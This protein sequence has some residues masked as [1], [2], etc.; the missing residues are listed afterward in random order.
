MIWLTIAGALLFVAIAAVLIIN[1]TAS[2]PS[3]AV[4]DYLGALSDGDY[5]KAAQLANPA[6]EYPQRAAL[7][8]AVATSADNRIQNVR[9]GEQQQAIGNELASKGIT[10]G[11]TYF[12]VSYSIDGQAKTDYIGVKYQGKKWLFIDSWVVSKP[13]LRHISLDV[14][15]GISSDV[16][17]NGVKINVK[18]ASDTKGRIAIYPGKYSI[19]LPK[20]KW[21]TA[22][23]LTVN[24]AETDGGLSSD[25][26]NDDGQYV[27]GVKPSQ[28]LNDAI[29]AA[30]RKKVDGCVASKDLTP[31]G[32]D[33]L[34]GSTFEDG[35]YAYTNITRSVTNSYTVELDLSDNSFKTDEIN[36][37]ISYDW[38]YD[39]DSDWMS[40]S[41]NESGYATGTW[42]MKNGQPNITVEL[43]DSLSEW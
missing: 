33:F 9:I 17:I 31:T 30:V 29:T 32:C 23:T 18:S 43:T 34:I 27:L 7:A 39:S 40:S 5:S 25:E 37:K 6:I 42:K 2:S 3:A 20:S 8:S 38:R 22:K 24:T 36:E 26:I 41:E 10:D 14:P 12:K 15:T 35:S 11:Q 1:N 4:S 13:M 21:Y 28:E 16:L 19:T